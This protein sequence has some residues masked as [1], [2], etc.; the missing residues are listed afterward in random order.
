MAVTS[1]AVNG[2]ALGLGTLFVITS[3]NAVISLLRHWLHGPIRLPCFV[4]IIAALVTAVD[5]LMN[6]FFH[7]L[8]RVLGL[9]VPLI[10]T[11][12][13][14]LGRAEAFAS[15]NP[16]LPA[17]LDGLAHGAGFL[18]V[19]VALGAIREILGDGTLFS[20]LDLVFGPGAPSGVDLPV[21]GVLVMV[22]PP[23]AFIAFGFLVAGYNLL[24]SRE[25]V[26][27]R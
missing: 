25:R 6:A 1:T 20:N 15:R 2:L 18:M 12:C 14:I 16:L 3:S 24:R 8:Y 5:L 11:N 13:A 17:T 9:F 4:I 23:G 22:L 21:D 7:P 26:D 10:V 19:L 27:K